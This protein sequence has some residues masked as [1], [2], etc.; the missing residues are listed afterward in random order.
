MLDQAFRKCS[1]SNYFCFSFLK[2]YS[3]YYSKSLII[4]NSLVMHL[5]SLDKHFLFLKKLLASQKLQPNRQE[6][7][8]FI[9]KKVPTWRKFQDQAVNK[10]GILRQVTSLWLKTPYPSSFRKSVYKIRDKYHSATSYPSIQSTLVKKFEGA[11]RTHQVKF[12]PST[13]RSSSIM[14]RH[15]VIKTTL[16]ILKTK[17]RIGVIG[18]NNL[19]L[20]RGEFITYDNSI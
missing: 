17:R 13:F 9:N 3:C 12:K 20:L 11:R 4:H 15:F 19:L 6:I 14:F 1:W 8:Y 5:I 10:L 18:S 16:S 2:N 7:A